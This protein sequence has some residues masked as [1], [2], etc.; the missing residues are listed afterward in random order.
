MTLVSAPISVVSPA[1]PELELEASELGSVDLVDEDPSGA[2]VVDA[3]S[4]PLSEVLEVDGLPS[5]GS[6]VVDPHAVTESRIM[7]TRIT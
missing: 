5:V 2:P 7:A 4:P 3:S 6:E 1:P